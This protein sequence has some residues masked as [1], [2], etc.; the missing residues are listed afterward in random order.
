MNTNTRRNFL[1]TSAFA[2]ASTMFLPRDVFST[3]ETQAEENGNA[4]VMRCCVMSDVHFNGDPNSKETIR[5]RRALQFMYEY[6]AAQPYDKFDALVVVGDMSNHGNEEELTLFKKEMDAAVKP[7]TEKFLC[8]GNHEF[9]GGNQEYWQSVFGVEPNRR[10]E[11]KGYSFIAVSPEKGT[12]KDG[13]YL[14]AVDFLERELKAAYAKDPKKP[15]FMFQH[16][17]V[18]PT[19]YGGRGFDD[20]GADD[21]FDI[22]QAYP[23]VVNFSGHTHYPINDPRCAWQGCFSAFG[24]GTL[25][26]ICHGHEGNKFQRYFAD[27][28]N[29]GQFYVMEVR[30]DNFVTL[31]PYD[32]TT[33]SFFD[34]VYYV[35]EPG[36]IDK[37][38]YTDRRYCES[39]KPTWREGTVATYDVSDPYFVKVMFKQAY[40]KDTT[41]GYRVDLERQDPKTNAWEP[42]APMYFWSQYYLRD[43]PEIATG[44]LTNLDPE[45]NYRGQ[46][47]ALNPFMRESETTIPVEFR[48]AKD[49]GASEEQNAEYPKPNFYDLHV[50]NGAL[51]NTPC[52]DWTTDREW[53]PIRDSKIVDDADA[54]CQV[55][56]F[57]Y[58][59]AYLAKNVDDDYKRLRRMTVGAKFRINKG[60]C[61]F[62]NTQ[63]GGLGISYRAETGKLEL[64]A[65]INGSYHTLTTDIATDRYVTAYGTYDGKT[66][67]FYV[68]GKEAA[69]EIAI[70]GLTFTH[71]DSAKAFALG[72]DVA[73][74]NGVESLFSGRI[75]YAKLFTWALSPEQVANL[76]K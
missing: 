14:Y 10:Y 30:A 49:P 33:D 1:K 8:M 5:F 43:M 61:I 34:V 67:I 40:C 44:E 55:V 57:D 47:T 65:H 35:G 16:Y 38:T 69:R 70:G 28:H 41:A 25:S 24:T 60:G 3:Y 18:S 75:A 48:T 12:M 52:M 31:K 22:L 74:N 9:Y 7:G 21:F 2:A 72:G 68:D 36:A 6:S 23:T 50:E 29:H 46:V 73:P 26:Y 27:D 53:K 54:G 51:V 71:D 64:W 56:E 39:E 66:L 45:T 76:S 62:S 20:W 15:I 59:G 63:M 17:P 42:V 58:G 11:L 37:Y 4:V 13:D 19:V 32:L